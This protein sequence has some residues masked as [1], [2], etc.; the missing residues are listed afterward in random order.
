MPFLSSR[1]AA[2]RL[3][4]SLLDEGLVLLVVVSGALRGLLLQL[5]DRVLELGEA[6]AQALL[7]LLLGLNSLSERLDLLLEKSVHGAGPLVLRL[8]RGDDLVG[9]RELGGE[10]GNRRVQLGEFRVA[11]AGG[12]RNFPR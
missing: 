12:G 2:E 8:Q 10:L 11:F 5:H 4:S 1:R 7:L 9:L 6:V 3:R